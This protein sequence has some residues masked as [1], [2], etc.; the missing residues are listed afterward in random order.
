M[1]ASC[2]QW[3]TLTRYIQANYQFSRYIAEMA[4]CLSNLYSIG[5]ALFGILTTQNESLPM[6]YTIANVVRVTLFVI[7]P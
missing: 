6:R 7:I 5:L 1:F 3:L 2:D 4:N